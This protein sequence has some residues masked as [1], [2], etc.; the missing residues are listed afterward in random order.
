M[1]NHIDRE[2][3]QRDIQFLKMLQGKMPNDKSHL[4]A[5]IEEEIKQLEIVIE[6]TE[7]QVN[8]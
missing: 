7:M 6:E 2:L 3:F 8:F 4:S 1:L 5:T